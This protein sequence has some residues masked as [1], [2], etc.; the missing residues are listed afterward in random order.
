ME[1]LMAFLPFIVLIAVFYFLIIRPQQKRDKQ[2]REMLAALKVGDNVTTIG[3]IFGKIIKIKDDVITIEVGSDKVN[4]VMARWAIKSVDN[5][6]DDE[7]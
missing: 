1:Q 7:E 3:G 2:I 4:I 5:E 6:S